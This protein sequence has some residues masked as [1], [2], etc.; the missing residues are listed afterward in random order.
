MTVSA[1][2]KQIYGDKK[3]D[4]SLITPAMEYPLAHAFMQGKGLYG[5]YNWRIN[6]VETMTY[7]AAAKRHLGQFLEGEWEAEDGVEHLGHVMACCA[8]ILD[9]KAFGN[10]IDNRP[11]PGSKGVYENSTAMIEK[12]KRTVE[13]RKK[14][15]GT[16]S[17]S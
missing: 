16:N 3:V 4:L 14:L 15:S 7:I 9:A 13:D 12:I 2:P 1:N 6:P 5:P 11:T 17:S 10:L 8:I